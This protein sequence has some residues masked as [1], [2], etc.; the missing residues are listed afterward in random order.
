MMPMGNDWQGW[1]HIDHID[2]MKYRPNLTDPTP[3]RHIAKQSH[4]Q[5]DLYTQYENSK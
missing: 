1:L 5:E 3:H 2:Y 4:M